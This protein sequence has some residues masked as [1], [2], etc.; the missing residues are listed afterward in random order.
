ME[1]VK[2]GINKPIIGI[3]GFKTSDN[4]N[5]FGN[6]TLFNDNHP[7][8]VIQAGG[9]P[10]GILS[11]Y[12]KSN[13]EALKMC[14]GI[15]LQGGDNVG[16]TYI[17]AIHYAYENKIPILGICLGLQAMAG[18]EWYN[19]IC[20]SNLNSE[21]IDK[22]FKYSFEHYY[23]YSKPGHFVLKPF[24]INEIEKCKHKVIIDKSSRLYNV[25]KT[26]VLNMPS[27]HERVSKEMYD[28]NS[29]FKVTGRDKGGIIEALES[30]NPD[31]W[32]V[33]VQ[34]HPE[35]EDEN[36]K[37]FERL[38]EESKKN[39]LQFDRSKKKSIISTNKEEKVL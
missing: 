33:G 9:I 4:V 5:T 3:I 6:R 11:P 15:I 21:D 20:P 27:L 18:Y 12:E 30:N 23:L 19:K 29:I 17:N 2:K 16:C 7:K 31:W 8:R 26:D 32:A 35:L 24:N 25:F 28:E 39:K 34:F 22:I 1:E 14:D 37:L 38:V 36:L 10:I 13:I